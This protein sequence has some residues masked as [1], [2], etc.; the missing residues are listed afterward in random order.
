[1]GTYPRRYGD[2]AVEHAAPKDCVGEL[3][4]LSI[5]EREYGGYELLYGDILS[6]CEGKESD[7]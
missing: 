6:G 7:D 5:F 4:E 2:A 1:M 3:R